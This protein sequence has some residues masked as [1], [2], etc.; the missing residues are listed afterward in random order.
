[1][2]GQDLL[3]VTWQPAREPRHE[4]E[5][6]AATDLTDQL[7]VVEF[8]DLKEEKVTKQVQSSNREI[9]KQKMEKETK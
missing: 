3:A 1:M 2:H 5:E 9:L 8:Q 7:K 6:T 4:V